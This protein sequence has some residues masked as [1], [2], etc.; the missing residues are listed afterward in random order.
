M[1][2]NPP[3]YKPSETLKELPDAP[4][5]KILKRETLDGIETIVECNGVEHTQTKEKITYNDQGSMTN[6]EELE[7]IVLGPCDCEDSINSQTSVEEAA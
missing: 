2:E 7:K 1:S 5:L 3:V 6:V 4:R